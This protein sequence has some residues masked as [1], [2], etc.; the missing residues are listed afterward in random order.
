[1]AF[2][3]DDPVAGEW[4]SG[5]EPLWLYERVRIAQL[6]LEDIERDGALTGPKFM[7]ALQ[8]LI[9]TVADME[10]AGLP[11]ADLVADE[12]ARLI[13]EHGLTR[14]TPRR[15]HA[16]VQQADAKRGAT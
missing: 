2:P 5:A 14:S 15:R 13:K 1:V 10:D 4:R 8:Q 9:D 6:K 12:W 7:A 3:A 11:A 16:S